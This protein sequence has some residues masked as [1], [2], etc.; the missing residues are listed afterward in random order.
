MNPQ[1]YYGP[2]YLID[3]RPTLM[4]SIEVENQLPALN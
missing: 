4:P 1:S 3:N 2:E